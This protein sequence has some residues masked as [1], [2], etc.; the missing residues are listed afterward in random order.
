MWPETARIREWTRGCPDPTSKGYPWRLVSAY[1]TN[2]HAHIVSTLT[3][4]EYTNRVVHAHDT[5][6]KHRTLLLLDLGASCSVILKLY[7]DHTHIS[8]MHTVRL[9]NADSRDIKPCGVATMRII[10]GRFSARHMFVVID[11]LSTPV[12]LGCDFLMN[13]GYVLDFEQ[14]TVYRAQNQEEVLQLLPAQTIPQSQPL[15]TITMDDEY[16]QEILT[17]CKHTSSLTLDMPTDTHQALTYV[18]E[19]FKSLFSTELGCTNTTQHII[20]TGDTPPIKVPP[21]PIHYAESPPT[22]PGNG[23][24]VWCAPAVYVP[25]PS[26]EIRIC[27]YY[28]Q[29]NS[30][31]KKDSYPVPC[32]EG[33]QQKL[34]GKKVF[35]KL[36]LHSAYR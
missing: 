4:N 6:N 18:L 32:A 34:A 7:V 19:E 17:P 35:S 15:H 16:P 5:L 24:S 20:D 28:V 3:H 14:C 31:T 29:L 2:A 8:P 27:I 36:D 13:H 11:H 12:I 10:L 9:V 26:G 22:T 30:V 25:K 23:P 1:T 33:P 21:H